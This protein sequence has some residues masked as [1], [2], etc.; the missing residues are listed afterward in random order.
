MVPERVIFATGTGS[1][2][3][4]VRDWM[5]ARIVFLMHSCSTPQIHLIFDVRHLVGISLTSLTSPVLRHP[6]RGWCISIGRAEPYPMT[7]VL[8]LIARITIG[9]YRACSRPE[10]ALTLLQRLDP[11]LPDLQAYRGALMV[12]PSS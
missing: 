11:T 1:A 6:R 2:N 7:Q 12:E 10:D 9:S 4:T 3:P 5:N 8:R